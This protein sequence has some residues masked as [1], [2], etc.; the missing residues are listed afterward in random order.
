MATSSV[1]KLG[2]PDF[3][4]SCGAAV[5]RGEAAW[6]DADAKVVWCLKCQ[7]EEPVDT[8]TADPAT[9]HPGSA[10]PAFGQLPAF[11]PVDRGQAGGSAQQEFDRRHQAEI[12]R[13][14]ARWGRLSGIAK[15]FHEDAA[16]TTAFAKGAAGERRVADFLERIVGA[17]GVLCTTG[18]CLAPRATSTTS[19]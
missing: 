19:P 14:E 16:T 15:V 4:T 12:S 10:V 9:E 13:L 7:G 11:Q 1:L 18:A 8:S 6:W 17:K 2:R 5:Q 3:C